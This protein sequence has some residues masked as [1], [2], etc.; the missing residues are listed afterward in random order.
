[1]KEVRILNLDSRGRI[2]I[3]KIIRKS[4]G[5]T[6]H[7]QLMLIADSESKEMKILPVGF[8][9]KSLKFRIVMN[10]KPGSLAKVLS[11]FA[12]RNI[13]LIYEETVVIEKNK[14]AICTVIGP[15]P[16]NLNREELEQMLKDEGE[17]LEVQIIPL[18]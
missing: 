3:P 4:L 1:M 2:V 14:T 13:S 18:E 7:S 8:S 17:A 6:H 9:G 11:V 12:K 15:K 10:D 16:D 5:I